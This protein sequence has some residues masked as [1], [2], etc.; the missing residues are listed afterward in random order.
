MRRSPFTHKATQQ[1]RSARRR[2]SAFRGEAE[3]AA[4]H[5]AIDS[6]RDMDERTLPSSRLTGASFG[7]PEDTA[8][9][10]MAGVVDSASGGKELRGAKKQGKPSRNRG[11]VPGSRQA[12]VFPA[13]HRVLHLGAPLRQ[14]ESRRLG[15]DGLVAGPPLRQPGS[16]QFPPHPLPLP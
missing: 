12:P 9:P 7:D 11:A 6:S 4:P 13:P 1:N 14:G 10:V 2:W 3:D 16:H 8:G 15:T 5:A